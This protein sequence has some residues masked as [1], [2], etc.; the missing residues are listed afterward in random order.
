MLCLP[1]PHPKPRLFKTT[2]KMFTC[3]SPWEGS[4]FFQYTEEVCHARMNSWLEHYKKL[5]EPVWLYSVRRPRWAPG[6][7]PWDLDHPRWRDI[8]EWALAYDEDP[9]PV[10]PSGER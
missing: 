9:D 6:E 7:M 4:D 8:R 5:G 2:W 10:T 1:P 3:D